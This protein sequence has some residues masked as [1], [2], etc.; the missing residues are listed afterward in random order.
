MQEKL[1]KQLTI[2]D[3]R[4]VNCF[5][6]GEKTSTTT[7]GQLKPLTMCHQLSGDVLINKGNY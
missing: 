3:K 1:N 2:T 6:T 7:H 4:L 5:L